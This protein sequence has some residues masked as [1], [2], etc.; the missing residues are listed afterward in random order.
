M[1]KAGL[2]KS[3]WAMCVGVAW[4]AT[5]ASGAPAFH[6]LGFLHHTNRYSNAAAVTPD[7]L[8]VTGTVGIAPSP[9]SR[10]DG[11]RWTAAS[12]YRR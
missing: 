7:G 8:T 12:A 5:A 10:F 6:S 2:A 4:S 1:G 3:W 11:F 9:T